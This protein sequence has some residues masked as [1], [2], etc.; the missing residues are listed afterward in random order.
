MRRGV[1]KLFRER[2][3]MCRHEGF[4][5]ATSHYDHRSGVLRF[6]LV[7]DACGAEVKDVTRLNYRPPVD[8]R[9]PF[10]A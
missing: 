7:C 1:S 9:S 8:R 4:Y 10:A 6:M 2:V 3:P 5:T